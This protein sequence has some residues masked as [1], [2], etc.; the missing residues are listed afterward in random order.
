MRHRVAKKHLSRTPAHLKAMRRNMAQSLAREFQPKGI[1]IGHVVVD[2]GIY[3]EKIATRVPDWY[4]EK[5]EEGLIG[6]RGIA[7]AFMHL[8]QQPRNAWTH[9]L[10]LR[11]HNENF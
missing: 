5:G 1:Q 3:G 6:L 8:Y 11:T 4:A 7:D 10:D 2:G 9:E